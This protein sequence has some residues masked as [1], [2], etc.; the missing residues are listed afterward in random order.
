MAEGKPYPRLQ[1]SYNTSFKE[2]LIAASGLQEYAVYRPDKLDESLRTNRW[3]TLCD[4]VMQYKDL[5]PVEQ[6]RLGWLLSKLCFYRFLLELIPQKVEKQ[7]GKSDVHASLAYLRIWSRYRL[8]LDDPGQSYRLDEFRRIAEEALPGYAR[9]DACYQMVAQSAK[10]KSNL[11]TCEKWQPLHLKAI[12]EIR[13]GISDFEYRVLMSRYH[14]VGGFIPQLKG[15]VAGVS[16]EMDL[17]EQIAREL[18][19]NSKIKQVAA[20][21]I[22]YPLIQSRLQEA[23]WK[24]DLDF[25]LK[26]AEEYVALSPN[27]ARGWMHRGEV[28]LQREKIEEALSSYR[29][30]VRFAPPG[31]EVAHFM[32]GQ[33]Y[34][35]MDDLHSALDAYMAALRVDPLGISA[36][37]RLADVAS[38]LGQKQ[39]HAWAVYLLEQIRSKHSFEEDQNHP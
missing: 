4:Y 16:C 23:L 13:G 28:L 5:K 20:D 6:V 7:I 15:D 39:A 21:E 33:C 26:Y 14:R 25:A 32:I 37:E 35:S 34:E 38:R 9:V 31:E 11:A 12:E 19:R 36:A 8:W 30:A 17:A 29:Q 24:D 1:G 3:Q 27:D 10:H 22:L 2:A 18:P